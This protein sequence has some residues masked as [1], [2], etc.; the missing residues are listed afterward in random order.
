MEWWHILLIVLGSVAIWI[1]LSIFLYRQLFKRIYD[2][3][4][5]LIGMPF[6]LLLLIPIA[7]A[8]PIDDKGPVFYCGKRAGKKEKL[9]GMKKFRSMKVNAPDIRLK[10]GATYSG[11]NDPRV[12]KVGRFLR[13]TSLDETPQIIDIL[14]GNMSF[15]GPRPD[16]PD[17]IASLPEDKKGFL[18]VRPGLTGYSQAKHRNNIAWKD[19]VELDCQ[20]AEKVSIFLDIKIIFMTI[21]T[22]LRRK[23]LHNENTG[24][25][26]E[27]TLGEAGY[28]ENDEEVVEN[29]EYITEQEELVFA[30]EQ[31][32]E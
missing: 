26:D 31:T 11:K 6:F 15:I 21:W 8:I 16:V 30:G 27:A 24:E 25:I 9:F 19:K 32:N 5:A 10:D 3:L 14:I 18:K 2:I 17:V 12:T 7:I 13:A 28:V 22:V 4:F 20:Y 29:I 1:L 23:N